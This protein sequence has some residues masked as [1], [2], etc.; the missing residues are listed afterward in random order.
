MGE[1][2][3]SA[4]DLAGHFFDDALGEA[5]KVLVPLAI[6]YLGAMVGRGWRWVAVRYRRTQAT[7]RP[8]GWETHRW[9]EDEQD[10]PQDGSRAA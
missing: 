2:I 10:P 8:E 6:A 9:P 1:L 4:G 3:T 5:A 7:S